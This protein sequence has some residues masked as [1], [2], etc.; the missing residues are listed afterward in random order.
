MRR[1]AGLDIG[2]SGVRV[3]V[4]DEAG[5]LV[6]EARTPLP[7]VERDGGVDAE[8]WWDA[9]VAALEVAASTR[10]EAIA[11][12]GTSGSMVMVDGASRPV[13]P[14]LLYN[15]ADFDREAAAIE[16]HA[17]KDAIARGPGSA[18]ARA[19]RLQA[20]AGGRAEHLCHQADFLAARLAGRAGVSDAS[21][22]LKTGYD[23]AAGEWPAWIGR[24][25]LDTRLLPEVHPVGALMGNVSDEM[26]RRFDFSRGCR[27]V[28]GATDS[29]AAFLGAGAREVGT[30]VTSLGTTL[31]LKILADR[32]VSDVAAGVY[33]HRV[34]DVWLPGGASNTGG[35]A[36]LRHFTPDELQR[37]SRRIDP[38][39]EPEH[40]DTYPLAKPGERFPVADPGKAAVLP[41]REDDAR[42]LFELLHAI[43]RIERDGYRALETLD[44]PYP[45]RVLTA[46][47]GAANKAW[48]AIRARVLGVPVEAAKHA[49]ASLGMALLAR[50]ASMPEAV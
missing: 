42:F 28:A 15:S 25:G 16:P 47:G 48:T 2:T 13:T 7:H 9:A 50:R 1:F 27:L 14:G 49:E 37:V 38:S 4:I 18:L 32:P 8:T 34:G 31:A 29:T 11:I 26:V 33:S 10:V 43:A 24:T 6:D 22:A 3:S 19:L 44:A 12:D 35:G 36:L 40:P 21:N 39:W 41:P 45:S 23:A 5:V 20:L 30:A 17:P 46:G